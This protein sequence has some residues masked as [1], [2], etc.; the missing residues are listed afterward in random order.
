MSHL[1]VIQTP[2][3]AYRLVKEV[4]GKYFEIENIKTLSDALCL[5]LPAFR[6]LKFG[7]PVLLISDQEMPVKKR[8][9]FLMCTN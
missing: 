8:V 6:I 1:A 4:N 5:H 3:E 7:E 9:E 2:T